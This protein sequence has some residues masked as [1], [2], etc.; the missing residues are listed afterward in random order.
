VKA[1]QKTREELIQMLADMI[2]VPP[3]ELPVEADIYYDLGIESMRAL[4]IVAN[5]EASLGITLDDADAAGVRTVVQFLDLIEA[6]IAL[7]N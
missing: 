4:Q 7:Q 6:T 5:M 2:G 3:D 1:P